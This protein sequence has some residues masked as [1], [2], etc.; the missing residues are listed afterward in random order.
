[1]VLRSPALH[2][3]SAEVLG[4]ADYVSQARAPALERSSGAVATVPA[5][6]RV[7]LGSR[8]ASPRDEPPRHRT[9]ERRPLEGRSRAEPLR[10]AE[11]RPSRA[12]NLRRASA[13]GHAASA[14]LGRGDR[15]R[16]V[17]LRTST[18]RRRHC[19]TST[20]ASRKRRPSPGRGA[21]GARARAG[22]ATGDAL[23]VA[24][25]PPRGSASQERP[26]AGVI[27]PLLR[28]DVDR[29]DRSPAPRRQRHRGRR[30]A[31]PRCRDGVVV[32]S[33][34]PPRRSAMSRVDLRSAAP[35]RS[36]TPVG[37][38]RPRPPSRMRAGGSSA[39]ARGRGRSPR[40][41]R[42]RA[43]P[44]RA[45][46]AP[47]S[48]AAPARGRGPRRRRG[49]TRSTRRPRAR[50]AGCRRHRPCRARR[51]TSSSLGSRCA[52]SATDRL[53]RAHLLGVDLLERRALLEALDLA[54]SGVLLGAARYGAAPI[55][56]ADRL[57]PLDELLEALPRWD[58][59]AAGEVDELA[60]EPQRI[61][62]QKFS[63][64]R[65]CGSGSTGLPSSYARATRAT[66]DAANAASD[67]ASAS[68]GW[69]SQTLISTVGNARCG[70]TLHQICVC[71]VIE[72]VS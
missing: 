64:I 59:L 21:P 28:R 20:S 63:S 15:T 14:L 62:R 17:D 72:P 2:R 27:R 40:R 34:H 54:L 69:P 6:V 5:L 42:P 67:C 49:G 41:P 10:D 7:A 18:G 4:A 37:A 32:C 70:R 9:R 16:R 68:S 12:G 23:D 8:T 30:A 29:S 33:L 61:A 53:R 58:R 46:A 19:S 24:E 31:S 71:S 55:S 44:A 57:H 65:R 25:L 39:P 52:S 50:S 1:M 38:G 51:E 22:R 43:A 36:L 35:A 60:R 11:P 47:R 66:S 56:S 13:G 45:P 3:R 26:P 48:R